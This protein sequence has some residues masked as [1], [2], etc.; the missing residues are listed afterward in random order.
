MEWRRGRGEEWE[1]E[2]KK[3]RKKECLTEKHRSPG[4]HFF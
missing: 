1:E 2:R 4:D 3:E